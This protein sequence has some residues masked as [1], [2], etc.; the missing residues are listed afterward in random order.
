MITSR[1]EAQAEDEGDPLARLRQRFVVDDDGPIYLDGNSLGRLPA[2]TAARLQ[3][4]VERWGRDLIGAWPGWI[5]LPTTVGDRIGALLGAQPGEVA[6]SDST[7]VNLYKLAV[8]ALDA[9][10][11]RSVVVYDPHDFATVRYVA[12]GLAAQRG[13]TLRAAPSDPIEGLETSDVAA[14]VDDEV[15]LVLLSGVN[16]RSGARVDLAAAAGVAHTHGALTLWDLS[17]AA[18][19]VPLDLT[20]DGADLAVGCTYK[21]LNG[22]PGAPAWLYVRSDLQAELRQPIWGW[23]GQRDQFAMGEGYDPEPDVRR[24]LTGTPSILG[25]AAVDVG[26]DALIEV[27]MPA[28]WAKTSRLVAF[29]AER[30]EVRLRPLGVSLA[31]PT[32]A[33][34]RGGHLS[35]GHPQAWPLCRRLAQEG[36][37]VVDYRNPNVLRLAPVALYTRYVDVW[38]AIEAM[39]EA[40]QRG[41]LEG[42]TE[43]RSRV[44]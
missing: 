7:T 23:F 9:R 27:G 43:P 20:H 24:F 1:P 6:V 30:A 19:A 39:A 10:A 33:D 41:G 18:G 16:F 36:T 42:D 40:L 17:H 15:A 32:E 34:R 4:T 14:V 37:V 38:D 28:L 31:S 11:N 25:L 12:Q 13:L 35:L 26:L 29:L 22:G 8:A 3:A 21:Y 2:A 44:T 5:D